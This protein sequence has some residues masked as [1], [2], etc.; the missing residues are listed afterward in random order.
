MLREQGDQADADR[1][2]AGPLAE[3]LAALR[4]PADSDAA[5]DQRVAVI[6]AVE[7]DRVAN[8]AVLAELLLP[9]LAERLPLAAQSAAPDAPAGHPITR[10]TRP[11]PLAPAGIAGIA[12]FI[13]EMIAQENAAGDGPGVRR[14]TQ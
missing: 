6:F 14:R 10:V 3:L 12:D 2:Q 7:R 5:F 4:T 9:L 8:A 1:V 11:L 13:D